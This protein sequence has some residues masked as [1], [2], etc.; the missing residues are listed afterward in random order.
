MNIVI[1]DQV[2]EQF[3]ILE[4][5]RLYYR[6]YRKEDALDLLE[7]RSDKK[8][9]KYMDSKPYERI[10]EAIKRIEDCQESFKNKE[11]INWVIVE[12][13]SNAFV[14][15]FG[16]W[17][18]IRS[19]CRAEI[20][21]ALKPEYW[22]KGYMQETFKTVLNFAFKQLKVHSLEANVNPQN[23]A[24]KRLLLKMGFRQEAYFRE[25]Y[26]YNGQ[27]TDSVIFG[28]LETDF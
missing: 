27:Y 19:H 20:G 26:L 14:G 23:E 5:E 10:D 18:L 3:P 11:G 6:S 8:V 24:S 12:K 25:N 4:S 9:M 28:M 22:G 17:R 13:E 21:Y 16:Y 2:F 15:D 7:V 1:N